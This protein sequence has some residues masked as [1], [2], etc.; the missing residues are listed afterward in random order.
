MRDCDTVSKR[1][2]S[3][4]LTI[5][6]RLEKQPAQVTVTATFHDS[7][8]DRETKDYTYTLPP[9]TRVLVAC[10]AEDRRFIR[11]LDLASDRPDVTKLERF[12]FVMTPRSKLLPPSPQ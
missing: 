11:R 9:G 7:W 1:R 4:R 5:L 12:A 8:D 3:Q 2:C 6:K 10:A